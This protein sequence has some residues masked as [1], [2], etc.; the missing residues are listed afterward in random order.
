MN[1]PCVK[2]TMINQEDVVAS[3]I[4]LINPTFLRMEEEVSQKTAPLRDFG[5]STDKM[6]RSIKD[7]FDVKVLKISQNTYGHWLGYL[8]ARRAR[9]LPLLRKP[10]ST[11]LMEHEVQSP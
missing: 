5:I 1:I 2:I 3:L 8:H 4:P 10:K 7:E 6:I 9:V 11:S